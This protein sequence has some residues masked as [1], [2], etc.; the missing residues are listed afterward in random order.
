MRGS[1]SGSF[2]VAPALTG[3]EVKKFFVRFGFFA[4]LVDAK[5]REKVSVL[6]P[7][8]RRSTSDQREELQEIT[9]AGFIG[10]WQTAGSCDSRLVSCSISLLPGV[11]MTRR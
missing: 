5:A 9:P 8:V 7:I 1:P 6:S 11:S 2:K 3:A 10:N 4:Q